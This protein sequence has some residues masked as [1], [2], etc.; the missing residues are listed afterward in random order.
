MVPLGIVMQPMRERHAADSVP[1]AAVPIA[2]SA[3]AA[4]AFGAIKR[5]IYCTCSF[6][7]DSARVADADA[8]ST[9][10]DAFTSYAAISA[11]TRP[12]VVE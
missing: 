2:T 5:F 12:T 6:F 10:Q 7:H 11:A 8:A 9:S 1:V 3:A 4:I